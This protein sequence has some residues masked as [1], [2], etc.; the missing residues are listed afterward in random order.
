MSIK[1]LIKQ[2][3]A[4]FLGALCIDLS[5]TKVVGFWNNA[6]F[7]KEW[8]DFQRFTESEPWILVKIYRWG[9]EPLNTLLSCSI[10]KFFGHQENFPLYKIPPWLVYSCAE[11]L[12]LFQDIFEGQKVR[13]AILDKSKTHLL[14]HADRGYQ[15]RPFT[16]F[17]YGASPR[18]I[19]NL[20]F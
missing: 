18:S 7:D 9:K 16:P 10:F 3:L 17:L 5:F 14:P 4:I 13:F 11:L 8:K 19:A 6:D 12:W 15:I 2:S 20:T 1:A